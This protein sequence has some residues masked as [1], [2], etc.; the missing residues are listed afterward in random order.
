MPKKTK[1]NTPAKIYLNKI[2]Q[3]YKDCGYRNS[4]ILISKNK[5]VKIK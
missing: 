3:G 1:Y 5:R 2:I 4:Y